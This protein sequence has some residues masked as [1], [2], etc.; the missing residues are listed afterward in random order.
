M[1]RVN[2]QEKDVRENSVLLIS[3]LLGGVEAIVV[4][5]LHD[6]GQLVVDLLSSP[7]DSGRVLGHLKSRD[8]DTTSVGGLGRSEPTKYQER[9]EDQSN[10][11]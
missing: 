3:V 11:I 8:G 7:L 9:W 4:A 5:V 6:G 10:E 2:R 1:P